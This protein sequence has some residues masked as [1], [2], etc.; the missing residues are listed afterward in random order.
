[1]KTIHYAT[2]GVITAEKREFHTMCGRIFDNGSREIMQSGYTGALNTTCKKCRA[3]LD[4]SEREERARKMLEKMVSTAYSTGT[5][6]E[7]LARLTLRKGTD[8]A[9]G[10]RNTRLIL[11]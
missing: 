4:K 7:M 3:V 6:E 9:T 8:R 1:M 2:V 10:V 5:T 11:G